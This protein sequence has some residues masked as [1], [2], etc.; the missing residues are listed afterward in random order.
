[1]PAR[2]AKCDPVTEGLA[3]LLAEP[4]RG[5]AHTRTVL[6]RLQ[7]DPAWPLPGKQSPSA[8]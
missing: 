5:L 8:L 6:E 3:P 4:V 1:V 2:E 7:F